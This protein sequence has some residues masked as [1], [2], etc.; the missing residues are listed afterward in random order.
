MNCRKC[1]DN[2]LYRLFR[3]C[4]NTYSPTEES[5]RMFDKYCIESGDPRNPL[6]ILSMMYTN[7][8][9]NCRA[10]SKYYESIIA[11]LGI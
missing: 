6:T 1:N 7:K 11:R 8:C 5:L 10:Y 3:Y 4:L 9:E 2:Y